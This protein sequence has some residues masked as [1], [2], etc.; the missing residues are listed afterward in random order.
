MNLLNF[1]LSE[2][3]KCWFYIINEL[4]KGRNKLK[5]IIYYKTRDVLSELVSLAQSGHWL[6]SSRSSTIIKS[7]RYLGW[8]YDGT[9]I[10]F[11]AQL[12]RDL[13]MIRYKLQNDLG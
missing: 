6:I 1:N 10:F 13:R 9:D 7:H 8:I 2:S 11:W 5:A 3:Y 4:E 12:E